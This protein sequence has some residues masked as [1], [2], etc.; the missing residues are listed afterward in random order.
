MNEEIVNILRLVNACLPNIQ[1]TKV[2]NMAKRTP[3]TLRGKTR[4]F[5]RTLRQ[6]INSDSFKP[7]DWRNNGGGAKWEN[8]EI[9]IEPRRFRIFDAIRVYYCDSCMWFS[10]LQRWLLRRAVRKALVR[11]AH[12]DV[13][14]E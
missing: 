3:K 2:E 14:S 9:F 6:A 11:H 4:A 8:I 5:A 12:A 10:L 1:P 13:K 7:S